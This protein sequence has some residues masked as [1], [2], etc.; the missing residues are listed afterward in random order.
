MHL[1][2]IDPLLHRVRLFGLRQEPDG[3]PTPYPWPDR[4]PPQDLAEA[5]D[6]IEITGYHRRD[7]ELRDLQAVFGQ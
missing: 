3:T 7:E 5:A 4:T 1:H 6:L 2:L